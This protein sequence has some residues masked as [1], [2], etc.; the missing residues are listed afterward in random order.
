MPTPLEI[1]KILCWD[2][3]V[4]SFQVL[5]YYHTELYPVCC[6]IQVDNQKIVV[7]L[8]SCWGFIDTLNRIRQLA[9]SVPGLSQKHPEMRLFFD[10][11]GLAEQYRHYIQHLRNEIA[12]DPPNEFPVWGSLSWVDPNNKR[13]AHTAILGAQINGVN[14]SSCVFDT[15]EKKWVSKVCLGVNHSSFNFD[16]IFD[17][18]LRFKCFIIS[19]FLEGTANSLNYQHRLPIMTVEFPSE[20]VS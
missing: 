4:Y 19:Y 18:S 9:Q 10:A 11:T 7:A 3:L 13:R 8:A 16:S 17:A 1:R 12:K 5:E 14:Y 2:G 20:I 6:E 15:L